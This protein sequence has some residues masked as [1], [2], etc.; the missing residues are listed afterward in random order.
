MGPV[1]PVAVH[2]R[3]RARHPADHG[4]HRPVRPRGREHRRVHGPVRHRVHPA[5]RDLLAARHLLLG[6]DPRDLLRLARAQHV[7]RARRVHRIHRLQRRH[8]HRRARRQLVHLEVHRPVGAGPHRL[9][10]VRHHHRRA[11]LAHRVERRVRH[12]REPRRAARQG[13]GQRQPHRGVQ[14]HRPERPAP[15]GGPQLSAVLRGQRRHH[16]RAFLSVQ[17]RARSS[18]QLLHRRHHP[19][20]HRTGHHAPLPGAQPP[21]PAPLAV[22]RRHGAHDRRLHAVHHRAHELARRHRRARPLLPSRADHPDDRHPEHDRLHRI[23][24][25]QDRQAQRGRHPLRAPDARQDRWRPVQ[26]HRGLRGRRRRN[27]R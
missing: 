23:R 1:P 20:H 5:R 21:H 10:G 4:V 6:H 24:P 25:A 26:R 11:R 13:R 27:G 16:R 22:H 19:G 14:G 2:R 8:R 12:P 7:H 15:V 18:G 9:G 17:V 3:H